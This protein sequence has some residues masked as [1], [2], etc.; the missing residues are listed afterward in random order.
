MSRASISLL[1]KPGKDP[2]LLGNHRPLSLLNSDYKILAKVL[3]LRLEKVVPTIVHIDQVGF[4]PGRLSSNNMRRVF[5]VMHKAS[6]SKSPAISESLD[7]EK[8]FNLI[9]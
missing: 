6:T 7:A 8:A 2:T 1:P 3:A 5:Q 4:I 9:E